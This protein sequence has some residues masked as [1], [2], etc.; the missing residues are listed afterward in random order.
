[1][2]NFDA[3]DLSTLVNF[4]LNATSLLSFTLVAETLVSKLNHFKLVTVVRTVE[5]ADGKLTV[6]ESDVGSFETI[7]G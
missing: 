7:N 1:M 3:L 6:K 4:R 5:N 2:L